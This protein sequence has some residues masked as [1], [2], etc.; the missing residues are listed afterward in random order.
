MAYYSNDLWKDFQ[1]MFP[2]HTKTVPRILIWS[3]ILI[4]DL[5]IGAMVVAHF[6]LFA[7][8]IMVG[9]MTLGDNFS[10]ALALLVMIG[11]SGGLFLLESVIWTTFLRLFR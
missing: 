3:V 1:S 10:R 9:N 6:D 8:R 5:I 7:L 11:V 2:E 4:I